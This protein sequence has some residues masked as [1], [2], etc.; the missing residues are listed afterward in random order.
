MLL[1]L[2]AEKKVASAPIDVSPEVHKLAR[3][4]SVTNLFE[5][6]LYAGIYGNYIV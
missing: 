5:G 2:T 6:V 1:A 3:V 4:V